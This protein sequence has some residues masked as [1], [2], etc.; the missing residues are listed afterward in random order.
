MDCKYLK[1]KIYSLYE[2]ETDKLFYVGSTKNTLNQRKGGHL[3]K[4]L[5]GSHHEVC[6]HIRDLQGKFYIKLVESYP[7]RSRK[8][9]TKREGEIVREL[10]KKGIILKNKRLPGRTQAEY[11]QLHKEKWKEW[12]ALSDLRHRQNLQEDRFQKEPLLSV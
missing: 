4:A 9:L 8:E 10:Q 11:Y 7:C 5:K 12:K 6:K 1:G 2:K 3:S